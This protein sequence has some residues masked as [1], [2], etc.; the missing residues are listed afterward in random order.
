MDSKMNENAQVIVT[1]HTVTIR[2]DER[3]KPA[4]TLVI[5]GGRRWSSAEQVGAPLPG[6]VMDALVKELPT[7][8]SAA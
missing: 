6:W 5:D 3:G 4:E 1:G 8:D 7:W 2:Y